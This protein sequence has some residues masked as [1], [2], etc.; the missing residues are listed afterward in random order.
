MY[1]I[2]NTKVV[3]SRDGKQ[4]LQKAGIFKIESLLPVSIESMSLHPALKKD[5]K[6]QKIHYNLHMRKRMVLLQ[7]L[8]GIINRE[9]ERS[10]SVTI[11]TEFDP[12][13]YQKY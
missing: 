5:E 7:K 10:N 3:V 1:A 9:T 12:L 8:L 2:N 13:A 6:L 4:L 11:E